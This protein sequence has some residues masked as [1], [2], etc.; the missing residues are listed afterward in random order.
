MTGSGSN[1]N[2]ISSWAVKVFVEGT[3]HGFRQTESSHNY[4]KNAG[5]FLFQMIFPTCL[6]SVIRLVKSYSLIWGSENMVTIPLM[7][8][9]TSSSP[10]EIVIVAAPE[11]LMSLRG[12]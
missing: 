3:G 10:K 1:A 7:H 12:L 9:F 5:Q 11:L 2:G 8:C 4:G 6:I